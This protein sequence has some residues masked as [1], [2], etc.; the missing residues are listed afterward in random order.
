MIYAKLLWILFIVATSWTIVHAEWCNKECKIKT[1]NN[2]WIEKTLSKEIVTQCKKTAKDPVHCIKVMSSVT[3]AES[4]GWKKCI[5]YNCTGLGGWRFHYE[6]HKEATKDWIKRYNKYWYKTKS[7]SDFYPKKWEKSRTGY[8][9]SEN[10][11]N[12]S[13]G[14]PNW[15]SHAQKFYNSITF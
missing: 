4:G 13:V 7:M 8:C 12:S 3:M 9:T 15:L 6:S 5:Y 14:C 2:L 11:S 10:S 1:L